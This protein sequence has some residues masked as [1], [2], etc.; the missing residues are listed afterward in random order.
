MT[1][2]LEARGLVFAY[3]DGP[4]VLDGADLAVDPGRRLAVL[5]P[6]G[7]GK[8]TLFRLLLGLLAP[9]AGEVLLDGEPVRRT[10]RG[11]VRLRESAQLVLQ[12]P[13]DQ[14]FSADVAQDVSF[15]PLNLGLDGAEVDARVHDALAAVGIADLA[16]RPTH[17]LSFGQRK[18]VAIAGALAVRPRVLVLDEPT[19][20]LDPA[21]VEELVVVL[22][23]LQRAGTAV[24][25]STHDVDLAHRW[26]D[27]VAV[28][29]RGRVRRGPAAEILGDAALLAD[30]R[31]GPAWA[32]AVARLLALVGLPGTTPAT[33]AELHEVLS[34]L[35]ARE[36]PAGG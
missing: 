17:R 10:R 4:V 18:R 5:G 22:E 34:G 24:V 15:G 11:L 2:V 12:D 1:A 23:D 8:T 20:G 28:V 35:A 26:A 7:G 14:L 27:D 19:A 31:L 30:A 16:D 3:P 29:A 32:P 21:G 25:L 6:N 9:A 33:A 13:D 36:T